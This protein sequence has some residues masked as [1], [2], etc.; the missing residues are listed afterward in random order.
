MLGPTVGWLSVG[1]HLDVK[2]NGITMK[3]KISSNDWMAKIQRLNYSGLLPLTFGMEEWEE[4][5]KEEEEENEE[6]QEQ[7]QQRQQLL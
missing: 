4:K 1:R 5:P 7:Q 6:Q 3:L 2:W